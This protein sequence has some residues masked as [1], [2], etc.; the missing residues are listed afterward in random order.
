MK[1]Y[2]AANGNKVLQVLTNGC[3]RLQ[4]VRVGYTVPYVVIEPGRED[5]HP[6]VEAR[7]LSFAFACKF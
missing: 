6:Q 7:E 1:L 4:T 3:R 5:I 2:T